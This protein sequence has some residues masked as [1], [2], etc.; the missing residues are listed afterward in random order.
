M[1]GSVDDR[2]SVVARDSSMALAR[3]LQERWLQVALG[4]AGIDPR[5]WRPGSGVAR[6]IANIEA[7]YTYYGRLFLDHPYLQWAGMAN[8]IGPAFYAGFRDIGLLPDGARHAVLLLLGRRKRALEDDA[9]GEL[10]FYE[11]TF[12]TMQKKI[13]EDQAPMHEAY[14]ANGIAEL[15]RF[16]DAGIVDDATLQGWRQIDRGR[17]EGDLSLLAAGNRMLLLR[18]QRDIIDRFYLRMLSRRRPEGAIFTYLL[19]LAGAPSVPQA[20]S[21]PER[22]PLTI[23]VSLPIARVSVGT[24]LADGD[25]AIFANRWALIDRDTLPAYIAFIGERIQQARE[26]VSS[27]VGKRMQRYRI[28]RRLG[29]LLAAAFTHWRLEAAW[30]RPTWRVL[31]TRPTKPVA[32]AA[33]QTL[34]VDL[35]GQPPTRGSLDLGE[36]HSRVWMNEDR[37][38]FSLTVTLPSGRSCRA[39]AE[40]ALALADRYG[41]E[42]NRLHAQLGSIDAKQAE[43]TLMRYADDWDLPRREITDWLAEERQ[44]LPGDREYGTRVFRAPPDGSVQLELEVAHH[45]RDGRFAL[46]ALFSW[47]AASAQTNANMSIRCI[48]ER[49][50]CQENRAARHERGVSASPASPS[51]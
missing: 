46:T 2:R 33:V 38:P 20:R 9:A 25:I 26:L 7:V 43:E 44:A 31:R 4:R 48:P 8:M 16:Y 50:A 36:H 41:G 45:V 21:Y 1:G 51:E 40:M 15:E 5:R 12:L 3:E 13:F 49:R 17:H 24:P 37:A 47:R 14:L 23:V 35:R 22:Y 28:I 11:T 42:P 27:S 19:T 10:G 18:E 39:S 32:Y 6:N 34:L 30:A 29:R